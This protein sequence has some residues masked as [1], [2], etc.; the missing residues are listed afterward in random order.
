[1]SIDLNEP[2]LTDDISHMNHA[3]FFSHFQ[4]MDFSNNWLNSKQNMFNPQY[5]PFANLQPNS[6]NYFM[7]AQRPHSNNL[8]SR[9]PKTNKNNQIENSKNPT[10]P[11]VLPQPT[12]VYPEYNL[13]PIDVQPSSTT[14]P[15][16]SRTNTL[17]TRIRSSELPINLNASQLIDIHRKQMNY[18]TYNN[19][20]QP[21]R[22]S[23]STSNQTPQS[24]VEI[25]L[26]NDK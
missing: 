6:S 7:G 11:F 13:D 2:Y 18:Q 23:V 8:N 4:G 5:E 9:L 16:S 26:D 12:M 17:P 3:Q 21:V 24:S 22:R 15:R 25:I 10:S 1:M 19:Q 20:Y 14:T